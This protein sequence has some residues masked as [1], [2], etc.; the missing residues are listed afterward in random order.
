MAL[1]NTAQTIPSTI[2]I[3]HP[4]DDAS[5]YVRYEGGGGAAQAAVYG[6]DVTAV[7]QRQNG[8]LFCV[9]GGQSV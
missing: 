3:L 4:F 1:D 2:R 8:I 6:F 7:L 9:A 5:A